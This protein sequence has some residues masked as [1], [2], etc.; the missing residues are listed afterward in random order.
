MNLA[1]LK[2]HQS[3]Q[4]MSILSVTYRIAGFPSSIRKFLPKLTIQLE[5]LIR[6]SILLSVLTRAFAF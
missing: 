4:S 1:S 3:D 5:S 6:G 2:L